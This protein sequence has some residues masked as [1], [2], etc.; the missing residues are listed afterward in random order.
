LCQKCHPEARQRSVK[1]TSSSEDGFDAR[2]TLATQAESL[3]ERAALIEYGANVPLRWAEGYAALCSMATPPGFSAE[4]WQRI[5]DATGTF[6]ERWAAIAIECGWS[7]L[8]IFGCDPDRP[9]KRFDA[10]GL[11]LLLD[12]CKIVGI[13]EQGADLVSGTGIRQRFRRRSVPVG[14]V[15]LWEL[16]RR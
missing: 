2:A 14:T 12:R 15:S 1:G 7:D 16:T 4:R 8:D 10:M 5:V 6:I 3:E 13:D 9:D 11:V